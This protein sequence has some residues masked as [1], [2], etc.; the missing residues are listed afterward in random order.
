MIEEAYDALDALQD[1]HWWYLGARAAYRT[2]LDLGL[3]SRP[4]RILE[5]GSGT[6]GNLALLEEYGTVCG[7]E[8]SA[9]ALA[10]TGSRPGLGLVQ[11]SADRLPF[12]DG[13]FDV[14]GL[15]GLIEHLDDDLLVLREAARV[16]AQGGCV[17][18][19]TS[20]LPILWSHHDEANRHR[21]RYTRRQLID[22]IEAAGLVRVKV[23]YQNFVTFIPTLAIR[24]IQRR[25]PRPA[26]YDMGPPLMLINAL[27]RFLLRLEAWLLRFV[28]FPVG[29]DLVAVARPAPV[30]H[31]T[32]R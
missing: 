12:S 2:L 14:V 29:V 16:C 13:S 21:R 31:G 22:L 5:V 25:S 20:A 23:S 32:D 11:G 18:L 28:S 7:L 15:F 26:S 9:R 8:L 17:A 1:R 19:L 27:L 24:L 10:M 6:G 30:S 3:A 4:G